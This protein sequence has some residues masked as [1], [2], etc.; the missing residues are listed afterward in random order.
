LRHRR[1]QMR[2]V[3]VA[4]GCEANVIHLTKSFPTLPRLARRV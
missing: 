1:V 4:I 2:Q 3:G